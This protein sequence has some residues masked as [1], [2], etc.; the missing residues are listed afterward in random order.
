MMLLLL[1]FITTFSWAQD[2]REMSFT[3]GARS[4]FFVNPEEWDNTFLYYVPEYADETFGQSVGQ[5]RKFKLRVFDYLSSD[6][7][8]I[9]DPLD[10]SVEYFTNSNSFQ[11]GFLRYRFSETFGLQLLDV[12][13]PRDYSEYVFNDLAWSKRAVFGLNDTYRWNELQIQ[14]ILTLWPNGDRLPYHD[15]SFDPTGG[16]LDYRGGV[17]NRPWFKDLEY[18]TRIKYLF[19][20]GLDFSALYYHHF[21]RPTSQEVLMSTPFSFKI[22]PTEKM[23]D[24]LGSS[25][26]FVVKDWVLRAD[27]LFTFNDL[28]Q[29]DLLTYST[30]NHSQLL[31]GIDRTYDSFLVGL[32]T[33][34]DFTAEKHFFGI[35]SEW[36]ALAWWKPSVMMFKN[37]ALN[38]Q[39]FQFKNMF[40]KDEWRLT[41]TYDNIHGARDDENVFGLYRENDRI[42]VD[43]SYTY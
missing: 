21:S 5:R 34:S 14:A 40:E 32:Q 25:L 27:Y 29:E 19:A 36:T 7:G 37:Y 33:Q 4:S 11:I 28:V 35:R 23:V 30:Q 13:N 9:I 18:G 8:V 17:V 6:E 12:A 15:S 26:S 42:M 38:D 31:A 43:A 20:N 22:R 39:W 16:Q 41:L 3:L 2:F 24:S 10:V 1:L